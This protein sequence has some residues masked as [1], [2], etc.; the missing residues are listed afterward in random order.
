MKILLACG[1]YQYGEK[2]RG[3]GTE[4]AAFLPALKNLGHDVKHFELWD[5]YAYSNYKELNMALLK[6]IDDYRPD[7]LFAVPMGYEI[8]IET[9]N[10]LRRETKTVSVCWT[11]D[12]SWKY[13]EFSRLIGSSFDLM[14]TT[15]G[16]V[17][18]KYRFDGIENVVLTQWAASSATLMNPLPAA[19]CRYDIVFLGTAHGNRASRIRYL[20]ESGLNVT[21]FGYGWPSGP[22]EMEKIPHIFRESKISLNYNNPSGGNRGGNQLKARIFEITG[23]GGLLFTETSPGLENYFDQKQEIVVFHND[24]ELVNL[25][26]QYLSDAE[27]RDQI[28]F[29]GHMRTRDHHTYEMRLGPILTRAAELVANKIHLAGL[30]SIP[31]DFGV[32]Y[33]LSPSLKVVKALV[34][35]LC[36]LIWGENRGHRAARRFIFEI[37]WR[38]FG[39]KT[40]T[41]TGYPGRMFPEI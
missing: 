9:L 31:K 18:P 2:S 5:R 14:T 36:R 4:Y 7:I 28:A 39:K 40:Y 20:Q 10:L 41:A 11:T 15:Y 13:K 29:A 30:I 23:S 25:I 12:D 32:K 17:L 22:V 33:E 37:S 1:K 3:L 38:L 34:T 21:C 8:W 26:R 27:S 6:K 35:S 19:S 24:R 16:S